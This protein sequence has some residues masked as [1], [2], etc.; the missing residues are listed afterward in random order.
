MNLVL[1]LGNQLFD[2]QLLKQRLA[3]EKAQIFLREDPELCTYFKFHK[4]KII[5]FLSAMRTYAQELTEAGFSVHYEKMDA[6]KGA[7]EKALLAHVKA[8]KI[9]KVFHFEIED[10]FFEKRISE[11]LKKSGV[12]VE[13]WPSPM[14]LTTREVFQTYLGKSK[15]PFMKTFYEQQRK[16]FKILLTAKGEPIGGK[17]SFDDQNRKPLPKTIHPPSPFTAN[18]KSKIVEDVSKLVDKK[19]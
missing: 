1:S 17:W 19:F 10:K 14:F 15:R 3:K 2:P 18:E 8:K 16:R 5:L 9:K 6:N 11:V 12:A 13:V 4:H 7:Y